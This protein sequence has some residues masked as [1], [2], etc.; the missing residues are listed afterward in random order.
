[1]NESNLFITRVARGLITGG[2]DLISGVE[3]VTTNPDEFE[4]CWRQAAQH[5]RAIMR[6]QDTVD[7]AY[8]QRSLSLIDRQNLY[9]MSQ[10]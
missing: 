10:E 9:R 5:C 3:F 8:E 7:G 2:R 1:M 6:V 4:Q